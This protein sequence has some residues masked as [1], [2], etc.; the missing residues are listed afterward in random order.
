LREV[1]ENW[2]P[3]D[4]AAANAA[5]M[6]GKFYGTACHV[7]EE[8]GAW[9]SEYYIVESIRRFASA[10]SKRQA[11]HARDENNPLFKQLRALDVD[12]GTDAA[13]LY[14]ATM[15]SDKARRLFQF[16]ATD[17]KAAR[18]G[19]VFVE[20]R[21]TV[22][23]LH[24]LL[25]IHPLTKD[26]A[27]TG[28]FVGTSNSSNRSASIGEWLEASQQQ[29]TLDDFRSRERNLVIA[30]SVLEEGIDI[31]ACNV[32]IC[33]NKPANLKS[34]IQRRGRAREKE[35]TFVLMLSS[36]DETVGSNAW[37]ALE[38]EMMETYQ[39]DAAERQAAQLLEDVEQ[40][41]EARLEIDSSRYVALDRSTI[42]DS[43]V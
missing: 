16:L 3:P 7:H 9:A 21:A 32:V 5:T 10:R 24:K 26:T 29:A 15:I 1:A 42:V 23:V 30:T 41:S 34:F 18:S 6:L 4:G 17:E 20:R 11:A 27:R 25:S 14:D 12:G 39:K 8:L 36:E 13:C 28:T 40:Q 35:S 19:I 33:F 22:A 2:T 38:K 43:P 37:E 31:S